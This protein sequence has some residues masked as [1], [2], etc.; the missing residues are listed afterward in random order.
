[1][2]LPDI[3]ALQDFKLE[4]TAGGL[5]KIR[6]QEHSGY[7]VGFGWAERTDPT[8]EGPCEYLG[9]VLKSAGSVRGNCTVIEEWH[10][11]LERICDFSKVFG[12]GMT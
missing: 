9:I 5:M 6:N 2:E 12:W 1:M 4:L 10:S 3:T 7:P 8:P 11:H